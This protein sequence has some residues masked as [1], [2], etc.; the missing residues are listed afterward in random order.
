MYYIYRWKREV[1]E[2]DDVVDERDRKPCRNRTVALKQNLPGTSKMREYVAMK[3][4][5]VCI[6]T[7]DDMM[8]IVRQRAQTRRT[9]DLRDRMDINSAEKSEEKTG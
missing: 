6:N 1:E 2:F 9:E 4:A 5:E 7:F 8:K 3:E